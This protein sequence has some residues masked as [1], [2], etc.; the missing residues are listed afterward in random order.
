MMIELGILAAVVVIGAAIQFKLLNML[1]KR[2]R[3]QR[4]E[5][6]AKVEAEEVARAAEHFKNV[7]SELN[8]WEEKHGPGDKSPSSGGQ[9]PSQVTT[10]HEADRASVFLPALG[11]D[12]RM[13]PDRTSSTAS[14]LQK[15]D[16]Y[17]PLSLY[18]PTTVNNTP[19][20][21]NFRRDTEEM[22]SPEPAP[23]TDSELESKLKLLEDVRR[24]R[25][26]V[27][28]S[29]E[30]I[31]SGT[32]T[33]SQGLPSPTP[34]ASF[35]NR[36]TSS[37]GQSDEMRSRR[38]STAS[39]RVLDGVDRPRVTSQSEWDSYVRDRH[40][41][42]PPAAQSPGQ[43]VSVV[44]RSTSR[45]SQY[46]VV[47]DSVAR[48]L[49]RRERTTSML[50]PQIAQD[51]GPR[52][53]LDSAPMHVSM[54]RRATSF[55]EMPDAGPRPQDRNSR[56]L[57]QPYISTS[58]AGPHVSLPHS[59]STPHRTMTYEELSERHRRRISALQDPVTARIREPMDIASARST[60]EQQ[61]RRE[62]E[63]MQRRE[64]DKLIQARERERKGPPP[65]KRET[66][67]ST[68][69]WRRS[70]HG[71]LDGFAVPQ[72]PAR[73]AQQQGG[74]QNKR[75]SISHRASGHFVN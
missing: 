59:R 25:E 35:Q 38:G 14:L 29:L 28:S 22:L 36:P 55:H 34:S 51:W 63:E 43:T 24:A 10:I 31:R 46:A 30:K 20:T 33:Q 72:L 42:S 41:L 40:V 3:Q 18:S 74:S 16:R 11:F 50:D 53:M 17:E 75:A 21:L 6:E 2:I 56:S 39:S 67:R 8:E 32:P 57:G 45:H 37:F 71:G 15:Q 23:T 66:L 54:G 48:A 4:E 49:D 68:D 65:D 70:V 61:Q 12:D 64:A 5:E 60:W 58:A 27:H 19:T 1:T 13:R 26:S 73:A 44:D 52:E 9:G 7:G 69:E 62:R 47:S